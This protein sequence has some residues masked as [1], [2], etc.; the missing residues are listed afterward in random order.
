MCTPSSIFVISDIICKRFNDL[1]EQGRENFT[2]DNQLSPR[3]LYS[4]LCLLVGQHW[5]IFKVI[6]TLAKVFS[7]SESWKEGIIDWKAK[8]IDKVFITVNVCLDILGSTF[9]ANSK[10]R[11]NHRICFV[12]DIT[13]AK[14]YYY[15]SLGWKLLLNLNKAIDFF[16]LTYVSLGAFFLKVF[17]VKKHI[18]GRPKNSIKS[19]F[20]KLLSKVQIWRFAEL[21]VYFLHF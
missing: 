9:V 4:D 10:Q 18:V 7:R 11:G 15:D 6:D 19:A 14:I 8:S 21:F 1:M 17:S 16:I 3:F 2:I 5:L 20:K 12:I 13:K